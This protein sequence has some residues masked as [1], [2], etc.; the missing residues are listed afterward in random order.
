MRILSSLLG[1][2]LMLF[3]CSESPST[4][5]NAQSAMLSNSTASEANAPDFHTFSVK[6][7]EGQ[8]F[9]FS[10]LRGKRVL[11]VNVA[12]K[13]GFTPQY[14][15]LQSLY[16]QYGGEN[17][18]IL[19]FPCNQFG[20]QEPGSAEEISDF[21]ERNYGVTFPILEKVEVKGDG[22]HPVYQWLTSTN[23]VGEAKVSWNFNKFLVDEQGRW[24]KHFGSRTSPLD[25][26][27]V[28]FAKGS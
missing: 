26:E 1:L 18:V 6:D 25:E 14:K 2:S 12:S 5:Q 28:A 7:I 22:Q 21:C 23:G 13:C 4:S 24:V 9:D 27:I 15:D 17:F 3:S 19:G 8:T 20:R 16:E 11:I 10:Q